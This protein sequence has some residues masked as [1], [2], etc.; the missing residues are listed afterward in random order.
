MLSTSIG[1]SKSTLSE[2]CQTFPKSLCAKGMTDA[3]QT[4]LPLAEPKQVKVKDENDPLI[5]DGPWELRDLIIV[6]GNEEQR[7]LMQTPVTNPIEGN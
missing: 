2:S 3:R 6:P 1:I 5:Q 4:S 7:T